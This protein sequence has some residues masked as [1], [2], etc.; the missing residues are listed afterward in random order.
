[1]FGGM[2]FH[3]D[4][5]LNDWFGI[6]SDGRIRF[7]PGEVTPR[8][9][10]HELGHAFEKHMKAQDGGNYSGTN[11]PVQLLID[12]GIWDTNGSF[13]TGARN[14]RYDRNGGRNAP[15]NG[16]WS[17]DYRD[18][19]QWHPRNMTDGNNAYEDWA[20]IFVNWVNNSFFPNSAGKALY[21]WA[22]TN[23]SVWASE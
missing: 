6:A 4:P 10:V 11:N 15:Q 14:G 1:M 7:K 3:S 17:D 13:V 9:T 2:E 19:W 5:T 16:Y 18:E 20:D 22:E 8:L 23:M 12:Y 21:D